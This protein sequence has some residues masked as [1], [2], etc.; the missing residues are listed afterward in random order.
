LRLGTILLS[1]ATLE[2]LAEVV[3][4]DKFDRYVARSD[5]EEFLEGLIERATFVDA[6]DQIH[7]CRDP[8]DDKFLDLAISGKADYIVSGDN[9]LLSLH[10]FQNVAV[11]TSAAFLVATDEEVDI[12]STGRD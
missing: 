2:E 5:R 12:D 9:D 3:Q 8:R 10:P 4:R 1:P 7:A 6:A 11:V